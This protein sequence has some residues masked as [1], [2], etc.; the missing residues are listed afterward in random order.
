MS[1][2]VMDAPSTSADLL[3]LA[4]RCNDLVN[5]C[6]LGLERDLVVHLF[7]DTTPGWQNMPAAWHRPSTGDIVVNMGKM[8]ASSQDLLRHLISSHVRPLQGGDKLDVAPTEDALR[9]INFG[10]R[11]DDAETRKMYALEHTSDLINK[12][13]LLVRCL[14]AIEVNTRSAKMSDSYLFKKLEAK[15]LGVLI[16]ETGHAVFSRHILDAW[17]S[18]ITLDQRKVLTMFEELRCESNQINRIGSSVG[19]VHPSIIV[20]GAADMVV[21]PRAIAKDLKRV[22]GDGASVDVAAL[23]LS[24]TLVLG[25]TL[26][27]VFDSSDVK[28]IETS[29]SLF[30][31]DDRMSE[32]YSIWSDYIAL[33]D[34][35]PE[36]EAIAL[37]DRWLKMF[38][39]VESFTSSVAPV[40]V[41]V[42]D[43]SS[44]EKLDGG[45]E[46]S[47]GSDSRVIVIDETRTDDS[48]HAD[49]GEDVEA[50]IGDGG[51]EGE[52]EGES[53]ESHDSRRDDDDDGN[54]EV[55]TGAIEKIMQSVIETTA[56]VTINRRVVIST[57]ME[58]FGKAIT[59]KKYMLSSPVNSDYVAVSK[60]TRAIQ[61]LYMTGRDRFS[62]TSNQPPGG[63]L[64]R[65]AVQNAAYRR[66]GSHTVVEQWKSHKV[67][68]DTN[69]SLS[70]GVM[71]DVSG[72]QSWSTKFSSRLTW[73]L[74]KA[75]RNVSARTA[76]VAF[77]ENVW[78]TSRPG[79]SLAERVEVPAAESTEMFDIGMAAIE[80]M[81]RLA[82]PKGARVLFVVTDGH[83]V[84]TDE[85]QRTEI[86]AEKLVS[87]GCKIIWICPYSDCWAPKGAIVMHVTKEKATLH[88]DEVINDIISTILHQLSDEKKS[89]N[90]THR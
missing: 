83:F 46:G 47:S 74:S 51:S 59:P 22:E 88:I 36:R 23:A 15:L 11:I 32:M 28:D 52:G 57:P 20:R 73:I 85:Y 90:K 75:F 18:K 8:Y 87:S 5:S 26:Y 67:H 9:T 4:S 55:S 89:I 19:V 84:A 16:H 25:R 34:V 86:W 65:A 21:D 81:L 14:N 3:T 1:T 69:P 80:Q 10:L 77:G 49:S 37:A 54:D 7:D 50:V 31:D 66:A 61:G 30:I 44:D 43:S 58:G 33:G 64:S 42:T 71:T 29:V 45:S 35:V 17:W 27:G 13:S 78:I 12:Y 82:Q 76:S 2:S 70:V 63:L 53:T 62:V 79:D 68:V 48:A 41:V 38:P 56:T 60:L 40:V 24:V 72:S 39:G 6:H